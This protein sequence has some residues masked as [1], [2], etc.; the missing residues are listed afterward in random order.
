MA[1]YEF[2]MQKDIVIA[3]SSIHNFTRKGHI[4]DDLFNQFDLPQVVFDKEEEQEEALETK[5]DL[6][7][8]HRISRS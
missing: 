5:M 3:C 8:L 4:H 6:V 1:P 7:G 2:T